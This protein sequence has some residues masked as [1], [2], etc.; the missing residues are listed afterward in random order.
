LARD[1]H[2]DDEDRG[3]SERDIQHTGRNVHRHCHL[4]S[5]L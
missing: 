4:A 1:E 2:G 5:R 3:K